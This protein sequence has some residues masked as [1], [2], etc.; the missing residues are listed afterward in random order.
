MERHYILIVDDE[1]S[2]R[3][4]L[5]RLLQKEGYETLLA[6][7]AEDGLAVLEKKSFSAVIS[8]Y[9]M[10]GRSGID[11][12]TQVHIL[13]PESIRILLTDQAD[14]DEVMP[15]VDKGLISH[16]IVKPWDR[17]TLKKT[18]ERWIEEFERAHPPENRAS[19]R[20]SQDET[21]GGVVL[22]EEQDT[23]TIPDE[24]LQFLSPTSKKPS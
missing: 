11:F 21:E 4:S 12:L 23:A 24:F 19:G 16:L 10:F 8:D 18:I 1:P 22:I 15:A 20:K 17:E 9:K 3:S 13:Y 6:E 7:S 5:A 2:I 14:L